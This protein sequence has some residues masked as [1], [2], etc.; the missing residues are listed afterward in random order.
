MSVR[1]YIGRM[2]ADTDRKDNNL[3]ANTHTQTHTHT[4]TAA[5]DIIRQSH[6]S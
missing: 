6:D 4:P 1:Y 3:C 2:H 5:A